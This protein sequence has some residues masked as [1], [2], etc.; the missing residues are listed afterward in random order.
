MKTAE[1]R[2]P[3][4]SR[5]SRTDLGAPG[6]ETPP[7]DSTTW[8]DGP[9][10]LHCRSIFNTGKCLQTA[11]TPG[12][13]HQPNSKLIPPE[14]APG[15]RRTASVIRPDRTCTLAISLACGVTDRRMQP[16]SA[17]G[18]A[19]HNWGLRPGSRPAQP[20]MGYAKGNSLQR[21][22]PPQAAPTAVSD[23]TFAHRVVSRSGRM[24]IIPMPPPINMTKPQIMKPVLN[25]FRGVAAVSTTLPMI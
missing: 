4:E 14:W 6:G 17:A 3:Y 1:H 22:P 23:L 18:K 12:R 11:S 7:G 10:L 16:G 5:G 21:R 13:C 25:P 24:S 2:E 19:A 15:G 9:P 20:Q 8:E